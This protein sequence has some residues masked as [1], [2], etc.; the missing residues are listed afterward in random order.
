MAVVNDHKVRLVVTRLNNQRPPI[1][2]SSTATM[3]SGSK[4]CVVHGT[5][6]Y[7]NG[8]LVAQPELEA[9]QPSSPAPVTIPNGHGLKVP[10]LL[11]K[12][13]NMKHIPKPSEPQPP[14][15]PKPSIMK[16]P[17]APGSPPVN[18]KGPKEPW[19]VQKLVTFTDQV[20]YESEGSRGGEIVEKR[21]RVHSDG[22]LMKSRISNSTDKKTQ[23][24]SRSKM[25]SSTSSPDMKS[26][27]KL[28][29][30]KNVCSPHIT[31]MSSKSFRI[32]PDSQLPSFKDLFENALGY[33]NA[34]KSTAGNKSKFNAPA[35][36]SLPL[37]QINLLPTNPINSKNER[38]IQNA[39]HLKV[40]RIKGKNSNNNFSGH[41]GSG[42]NSSSFKVFE[43]VLA[44]GSVESFRSGLL[45]PRELSVTANDNPEKIVGKF[46]EDEVIL[47]QFWDCL[48]KWQKHFR[49]ERKNCSRIGYENSMYLNNLKNELLLQESSN[50]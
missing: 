4:G 39:K 43:R 45:D 49:E 6:Q 47:M 26:I 44:D 13:E 32:I 12:S 36:P 5:R 40:P 2:T 8:T 3:G 33:N 22:N 30:I 48:E 28:K 15:L 27:N 11:V 18:Q 35:T 20:Q 1:G 31:P 46:I 17:L 7:I 14:P 24:V 25:I 41:C 23:I 34:L 50:R 21:N 19:E 10:T 38:N 9:E 37:I 16:K 42:D 29:G